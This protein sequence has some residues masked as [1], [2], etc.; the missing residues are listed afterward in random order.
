MTRSNG[1]S[2][3]V[4]SPGPSP[5][6]VWSNYREKVIS[7]LPLADGK[8]GGWGMGA[9]ALWPG[10]GVTDLSMWSMETE[11]SVIPSPGRSCG[12]EGHARAWHRE[13]TGARRP[14]CLAECPHCVPRWQA[15][16]EPA[17]CGVSAGAR[18]GAHPAWLPSLA[19]LRKG[20][21]VGLA[22][23][24]DNRVRRP[25]GP[26]A[27]WNHFLS[28][29]PCHGG[30]AAQFRTGKARYFRKCLKTKINSAFN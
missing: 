20:C 22:F 21:S 19:S 7:S 28:F 25:L 4:P 24:A 23:Q 1:L 13:L 29:P 30:S 2:L 6:Q 8:P 5:S 15:W 27:S 18:C 10:V 3:L 26:A 17:S 16:K 12:C 9:V 11:A 14:I